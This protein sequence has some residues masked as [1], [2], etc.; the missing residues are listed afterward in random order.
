MRGISE[1]PGVIHLG[2]Y[3]LASGVMLLI[4]LSGGTPSVYMNLMYIPIALVSTFSGKKASALFSMIWGFAP[5][6]L[7]LLW[8]YGLEPMKQIITRPVTF[9]IISIIISS[10]SDFHRERLAHEE[11]Y[12]KETG[13]KK[14]PLFIRSFNRGKGETDLILI[15]ITNL[16]TVTNL[17]SYEFSI[18]FIREFTERLQRM[19]EDLKG[20]SFYRLIEN[21]FLLEITYPPGSDASPLETVI[22]RLHTFHTATIDVGEVPVYI[23]ICFGVKERAQGKT[24]EENLRQVSLAMRKAQE[25]GLTSYRY[26]N[27]LD[28]AFSQRIYV[29]NNFKDALANKRIRLAYQDIYTADGKKIHSREFLARWQKEDGS[30]IPPGIFI[31]IIEQTDL[32]HSLTRY[33]IDQVLEHIA[34]CTRCSEEEKKVISSINFSSKDFSH[35]NIEYLIRRVQETAVDPRTIQ[36]EITEETLRNIQT[37]TTSVQSLRELGIRIVIDDFGT[38]YSSYVLLAQ[39]LI[40]G[41]KIDRSIISRIDE[42]IRYKK[43]CMNLSEYCRSFHI[44]TVAE[45]V[46]TENIAV[47]CRNAG[48]DL[49]QGFLYSRPQ[50]IT[51][52]SEGI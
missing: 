31:P 18:T 6:P 46:E 30:F 10:L 14:L 39:L 42:D 2:S 29:L 16:Q 28:E 50:L 15:S 48:I 26:E 3:M 25:I 13:L 5:I 41:V 33:V 47:T 7:M 32:I 11:N 19:M 27:I 20:V 37:L 1:H 38:G 40:D 17:F 23:E 24:H 49:L 12:D 9:I 51:E 36:V 34:Q 21:G 8:G 45:G 4:L 44:S 35:S 43:L 52:S 22:R